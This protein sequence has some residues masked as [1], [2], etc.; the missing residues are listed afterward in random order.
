MLV[1]AGA[2]FKAV[3]LRGDHNTKWS[4]RIDLAVVALDEKTVVVLRELRTDIDKL[5]PTDED[6]FD[7]IRV[8]VDPSPLSERVEQ[9]A[10]FYA[11]RVRMTKDLD[12]VLRLGRVFVFG[13]VVLMLAIVLLTLHYAEILDWSWMRWAGYGCGGV[14]V[15]ILISA[16]VVY[17]VCVD[18][19]AS[20]EILAET[21]SQA[22][23][24]GGP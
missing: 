20:G 5:L 2:I 12:R 11:A 23:G 10:T 24:G 4:S 15:A 9:T 18:R 22:G 3:N 21:A 8:S 17:S 16:M 1:L 19:L 6:P 14:G 13:L 7:P